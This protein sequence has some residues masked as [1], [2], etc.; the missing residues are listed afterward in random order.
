MKYF[1]KKVIAAVMAGAFLLP[2]I[3]ACKKPTDNINL[4]VNTSSLS[5]A[6][7]LVRF[8]NANAS[9]NTSL[10]A[11]ITVSVNG[12]GAGLVQVD[13]G[14]T[15]FTAVNGL[16]PLSLIKAANP[17]VSN[18]VTF[19]LYASVAGY[20]PVSKTITLTGNT[21][22][23]VVIALNE[24]ANPA[25]GTAAVVK[26]T[27]GNSQTVTVSTTTN[28]T[29][30]ES[31]NISIPAGTQYKD[32]NG[33]IINSTQLKSNVVY[34]GTGNAPAYSAFPGDFNA[35]NAIGPNGQ[36]LAVGS[37]F[38][39]AGL[40]SITMTAGNSTVKGFSKPVT[41][42][43]EINRNLINP[44]THQ[45]VKAGDAIPIWSLNEQT[46][47]WTYESTQN[48][49]AKGNN[50]LEVSFPITHLSAWSAN[51]SVTACSSTLNVALRVP[52]TTTTLE[53][54]YMIALATTNNQPV[55][56]VN[57]SQIKDGLI[58]NLTSIPADAGDVKVLVYSRNNGALTKIG[59]TTAFNACSQGSVEVTV[60][61]QPVPDYVKTNIKVTAKCTNKQ[62]VAYPSAWLTLKDATTGVATNVY[63]ADGT[64]TANLIDGH[65]YS[66]TTTYSG[67]TYNSAA[68]KL[69]K[70]AGVTIPAVNGLSGTANFNNTTNS[71]DV[72]AEFVLTD[73]N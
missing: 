34:F 36:K 48:I 65:S 11:N 52:N 22:S 56:S 5:K 62:V 25:N 3:N 20:V 15:N 43:M 33:A 28:A 17:S 37:S 55:S 42:S 4:I 21:V 18:P 60:N 69:D 19:T 53:G 70:S 26:T 30:T 64:A 45:L 57:V 40:L 32:G 16:L 27:T 58:T 2:G 71:I 1:S 39:T 47:Q 44:Q 24:Y 72:N 50:K 67:K 73:C 10:P 66:I 46:G 68:F 38:V 41:V 54:D 49:T 51:W 63:M 6:P 31:S 12:T 14:G 23:N 61:A 13:G 9:S 7:T 59:E 29:T 35:A 8:V